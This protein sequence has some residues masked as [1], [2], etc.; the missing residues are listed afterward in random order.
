MISVG[1]DTL[2]PL[3]MRADP[4]VPPRGEIGRVHRRF[5]S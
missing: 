4:D 3:D 2:G 5:V 1:C